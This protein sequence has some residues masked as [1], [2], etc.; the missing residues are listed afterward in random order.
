MGKI[1]RFDLTAQPAE[2]AGPAADRILDGRPHAT[3]RLA[4]EHAEGRLSAGL[5]E[6]SPGRWRVAYTEWEFFQVLR[7]ACELVGD[8][9]ERLTLKAGDAVVIEPG[10]TGEVAVLEP[11][12]KRF[13]VY[14]AE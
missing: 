8:D 7:G 14:T 1:K 6:S 12:A 11:M 9:G 3:Y 5:W 13:V 10:F 2:D 4:A